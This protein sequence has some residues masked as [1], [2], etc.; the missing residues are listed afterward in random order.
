M[1]VIIYEQNEYS[2]M[3][4]EQSTS[5]ATRRNL[6]IGK[7]FNS[8][9]CSRRKDGEAVEDESRVLVRRKTGR[10]GQNANAEVRQTYQ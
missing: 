4:Q 8:A 2:T 1:V 6:D 9:K 7:I 3:T 5:E 10:L